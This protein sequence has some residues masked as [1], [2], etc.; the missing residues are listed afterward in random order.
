MYLILNKDG[1]IK[2]S[3]L[4]DYV[5]KG[6]DGVN[7]LDVVIYG[8]DAYVSPDDYTATGSFLLP[9]GTTS[10]TATAVLN[11]SVTTSLGV[12]EGY[13]FYFYEAFTQYPGTL[14]FSLVATFSD[15]TMVSYAEDF[16]VNDSAIYKDTTIS[17]EE[18]ENLMKTIQDYQLQY[19]MSN[20]RA[21]PSWE[22]AKADL[23]NLADSQMVICPADG[24]KAGLELDLFIVGVDSA[25]NKK[26]YLTAMG[27]EGLAD[28]Y[29][30]KYHVSAKTIQSVPSGLTSQYS[31]PDGNQVNY[32]TEVVSDGNGFYAYVLDSSSN[33]TGKVSLGAK[34]FEFLDNQNVKFLEMDNSATY[35]RAPNASSWAE[36]STGEAKICGST[37][38]LGDYFQIKQSTITMSSYVVNINS[39]LNVEKL[40]TAVGEATFMSKAGLFTYTA[41]TDD[42]QFAPKKYVDD[43]IKAEADERKS[44]VS[45][46]VGAETANRESADANLQSQIDAINASQNFVATYATKADMPSSPSIE[47]NDCVL[48]LKDESHSDQAYVYKWTGSAWE[49]VGELGDYY[50]KA[51]IDVMH[52]SIETELKAYADDRSASALSEGKAYTDEKITLNQCLYVDGD[53]YVCVDYDKLPI[54]NS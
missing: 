36:F 15:K 7:F 52:S 31:D 20:V 49:G 42:R 38:S 27:Y 12:M 47:A 45:E 11:N 25:G 3:Q 29:V 37:I 19:S 32:G 35:L 14:K 34:V 48:V 4:N 40:F 22:L 43:Q 2:E 8:D 46:A 30:A 50:T 10:L 6:S 33:Y 28:W 44:D 13:R 41:P 26:L 16:T 53:G 18:Y 21:Y 24:R 23:A 39:H 5:N 54:I 17:W 9:D 51:Q 1:S